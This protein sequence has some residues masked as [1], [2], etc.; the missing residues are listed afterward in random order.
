[1]SEVKNKTHLGSPIFSL[2]NK[3]ERVIWSIVYWVFFRFS[4]R[5]MFFFRRLLLRAFG[6]QIGR[7]AAIYSSASIWLPANLEV[8][9]QSA[10]GPGVKIYNQGRISIGRRVIVSQY[11]HLCASTHDYDK[12]LHP[13]IL[14]PIEIEDDCWICADA[15]IGPGAHVSKGSV[16]GGRAVLF[17]RTEEWSVYAGNP[18]LKIKNRKR[19]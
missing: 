5:P 18:A 6:A 1:M 9:D 14:R 11:A 8:G 2:R 19:F 7:G 3:V 17:K 13:L 4:P 10:I 16:I 15:F 12:Q